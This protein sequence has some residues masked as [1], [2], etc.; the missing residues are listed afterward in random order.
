MDKRAVV[1]R[2]ITDNYEQLRT[3]IIGKLAGYNNPLA[4]DL[5]ASTLEQF[6][7]KDIDT[8]YRIVTE[9]KPEFYITRMG[10]LNLKST[11]SHFYRHYRKPTMD[12]REFYVNKVYKG[13]ESAYE[14][15]DTL[16]GDIFTEISLKHK[17]IRKTM[18]IMKEDNFYYHDIIVKIY[19]NGW[20]HPDY[21]G[22]Y[23]I[24]MTELRSNVTSARQKFKLIFR[25]VANG[26]YN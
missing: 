7:A 2:W 11:T 3:N 1:N 8:Q 23:D 18:K 4:E 16:S 25:K 5:L 10:A 22:H 13:V 17:H 26:E 15:D 9:E 6:L 14:L 20:S 24:P 19:L 12:I 21:A